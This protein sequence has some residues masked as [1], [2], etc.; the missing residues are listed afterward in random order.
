MQ[1]IT[2][3]SS[4]LWDYCEENEDELLSAVLLASFSLRISSR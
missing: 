3:D 2:I 1:D 4:E